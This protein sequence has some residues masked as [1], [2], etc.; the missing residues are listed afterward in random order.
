M[1]LL[2]LTF[3]SSLLPVQ[4]SDCGRVDNTGRQSVC[5]WTAK[6]NRIQ[7]PD[8][9]NV[10]SVKIQESSPTPIY[11]QHSQLL[12]SQLLYSHLL[13]ATPF[14]A[15]PLSETV[16]SATLVLCSQPL[17]VTVATIWKSTLLSAT[18]STLV[19]ATLAILSNSTSASLTFSI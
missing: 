6:K 2:A 1:Y 8:Q 7:E 16:L 4:V 13:S 9:T 15:T 17:S 14:S 12:H 3:F 11:S 10:G 18:V 19:T 5:T